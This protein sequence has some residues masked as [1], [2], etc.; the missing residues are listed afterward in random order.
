M[1][2]AGH[3]NCG[4]CRLDDY[5]MLSCLSWDIDRTLDNTSEPINLEETIVEK[6]R[7]KPRVWQVYSRR[8]KVGSGRED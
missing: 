8:R 1:P 4:Y 7:E 5:E 2:K 6:G 3:L